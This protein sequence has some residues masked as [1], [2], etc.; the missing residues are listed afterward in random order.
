[1][2]RNFF[3]KA[4]AG[5]VVSLA[6]LAWSSQ[7][8]AG[9][10]WHGSSGGYGGSSGGYGGSSG[11]WGGSSGGYGGSSGGWGGS[12]GGYGGSSGGYGGGWGGHWAHKHARRAAWGSSGGGWGGS[13]GGY[14]GSSGGW[15]GSSGG[16]GGSSGGYG[17]SSGG[18]SSGGGSYY[19]APGVELDPSTTVPMVPGGE[20]PPA[21]PAPAPGIAPAP[22]TGQGV[23]NTRVDG[24]LAV[25]VPED[26]KIFVNGQA[27]TSTGSTRQYVSRDLQSGFSYTYE[28]RAEVVRDGRTIEQVK[29]VDLRA[30]Q[31]A[32]VAFD[33]PATDSS[34]TSLTV[35]VPA[36]A[37]VY[38]AG[39]ATKASGETRV[40]RTTGLS[41]NKSWEGYTIRVELERGGRTVTKEETIT[42]KAGQSQELSFDFEGD[43]VASAR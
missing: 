25:N 24:L 5:A 10:R 3:S 34:E 8:E 18:G 13:S 11:G 21:A 42:L 27:T 28:V 7:A 35:H 19:Y 23:S 39:N 9:W 1:M 33:F 37:K 41:S 4:A 32:N 2:V 14:G 26:A 17:G 16:Y 12:S 31:T 36:D 40:F 30:G 6:V 15:G 43:K 22:G 29:K 20:I 38:L